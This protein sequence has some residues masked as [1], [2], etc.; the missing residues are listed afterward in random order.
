MPLLSIGVAPPVSSHIKGL[1]AALTGLLM[2][3]LI[4][5]ADHM[6]WIL[7]VRLPIRLTTL[8]LSLSVPTSALAITT[9][10]KPQSTLMYPSQHG[11]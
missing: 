8:T 9:L 7:A 6:A 4:S 11:C 1:G 3:L 5:L 2:P 10:T